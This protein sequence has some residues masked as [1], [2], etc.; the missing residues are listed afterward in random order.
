MGSPALVFLACI[1]SPIGS[2]D[3][4]EAQGGGGMTMIIDVA[5]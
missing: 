3:G 2:Y 1:G 4:A 5:A